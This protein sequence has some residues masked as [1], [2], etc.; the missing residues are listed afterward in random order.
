MKKKKGKVITQKNEE[1]SRM[2]KFY[3]MV[4]PS[5]GSIKKR[6][7]SDRKKTSRTIDKK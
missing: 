1:I 7:R 5:P 3:I 4:P 6:K 2:L